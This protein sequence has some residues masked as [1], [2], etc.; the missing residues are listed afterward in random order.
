MATAGNPIQVI[1]DKLNDIEKSLDGLTAN[2]NGSNSSNSLELEIKSIKSDISSLSKSMKEIVKALRSE[3][4]EVREQKQKEMETKIVDGVNAHMGNVTSAIDSFNTT[5]EEKRKTTRF[6]AELSESSKN[7]LKETNRIFSK[8]NYGS[9]LSEVKS[10]VCET[11]NNGKKELNESAKQVNADV[12][13]ASKRINDEKEKAVKE[14]KDTLSWFRWIGKNKAWTV[15]TSVVF[16]LAFLAVGVNSCQNGNEKAAAAEQ[17]INDANYWD[18]YEYY[19]P[20]HAA[21][22]KEKY[23]SLQ[24]KRTDREAINYI[25]GD[26]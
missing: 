22:L 9:L 19:A 8:D 26:N 13:D 15:I 4:Q 12:K 10:D 7:L 24:K 25:N 3:T 20:K 23:D 11:V 18:V 14:V 16:V 6:S 2:E 17:V 1:L 21:W 5:L